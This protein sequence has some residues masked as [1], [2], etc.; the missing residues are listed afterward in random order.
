VKQLDPSRRQW[1]LAG[2]VVGIAAVAVAT[3]IVG[4][5]Q[6]FG[7]SMLGDL[8]V[9]HGAISWVWAGHPLYE[10][11]Y[12]TNPA[13]S[14]LVF[15]YPPFAALALAWVG[16]GSLATV[17]VIWTAAALIVAVAAV[18]IL[19]RAAAADGRL[20]V[21]SQVAWTAGLA[22]AF[23]FTY[24]VIH[25]LFLGQASLFVVALVLIDHLLPR[26]WRGLLIGLAAAIKLTP[27]V[28]VP[29]FLVTRQWRQALTSTVSFL[30]A[31]AVA[32]VVF[33]RDS[34]DYWT[35]VL[36]QTDRVGEPSVEI[37]K[38]LLGLVT[39]A[40]GAGT[41]TTTA[42]VVLAAAASAL[43]LWRAWRCQRDGDVV[44]ATLL[45]G[46]L[47]LAIS[48]ISWPHHLIWLSLVVCWWLLQRRPVYTVWGLVLFAVLMTYPAFFTA[49]PTFAPP[50]TLVELPT[51]AVVM[52][53]IVGPGRVR[54]D[55]DNAAVRL[56]QA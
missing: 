13:A 51:L 15:T 55:P 14:G 45:V 24:P 52:V 8:E 42:W 29:Y 49:T 20:S 47:S 36:W 54:R 35:R 38:S 40:F 17:K 16:W 12:T 39:R 26:R 9:Y 22:A 6:N 7:S 41:A 37:N 19:V 1:W 25:D 50:Q 21:A 2:V 23:L 48:P 56:P 30:G 4:L 5:G 11:T 34:L 28:F 31:T 32:A 18:I 43:A 44:G 27:L 3:L 46:V 10:W 33:P 53:L